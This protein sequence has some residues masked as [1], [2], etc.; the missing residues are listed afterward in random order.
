MWPKPGEPGECGQAETGVLIRGLTRPL[1]ASPCSQGSWVLGTNVAPFLPCAQGRLLYCGHL[2]LLLPF[3]PDLDPIG[4]TLFSGSASD[5]KGARGRARAQPWDSN[6]PLPA[7]GNAWP[8]QASVDS[9]V[10]WGTITL[11]PQ[12]ARNQ[13]RVVTRQSRTGGKAWCRMA[14]PHS[15]QNALGSILRGRAGVVGK[16]GW[17]QMISQG[18][19]AEVWPGRSA[20]G[21][22]GFARDERPVLGRVA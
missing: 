8:L 13:T 10:K 17:C 15:V 12:T 21:Q 18:D 6:P 4:V 16:A 7:L 22:P 9:V 11:F 20:P 1:W 14:R 3:L 5:T 2:G 19:L